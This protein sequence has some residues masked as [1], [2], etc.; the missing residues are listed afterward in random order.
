[1]I[2][3]KKILKAVIHDWRGYLVA[4]VL[5]ALATW[6]KYLAQPNI[7]PTDVP[8]LYLLAIVPTAIFFGL[9]P[10]I[11]VCIL[12]LLAYDYFFISPVHSFDV[13]RIINAPILVIFLFVG[14][15]FS[16]LSSNLRR[17]N[18]IAAKEIS[19]R[20]QT[21]TE[22]VKYKDHLEDL[23]AQ[24]TAELEKTNLNL[25]EEVAE[26]KQAEEALNKIREELELRVKERTKE[27]SGAVES[28]KS[29]ITERKL[30]EALVAAQNKQFN[31]V[32]DMLPAY[33][34]L[35]SPDYHVPFA[36]RFFRE[37][38]GE[39][40]GKRCF[41]YLFNRTEPCEVCETYKVLKTNAPLQWDWIGPDGHN[42]SIF[43]FP[44]ADK[45][46][47]NL[48]MEVGIDVTEEKRAHEALRKAHDELEFRV[49]ERTREL[50]ET[51]DYLDNLFNYANA[52]IIVWNP[53]FKITRFNH[54]F[55]R[56]TAFNAKEVLGKELDIL[57]PLNS[58]EASM[59]LIRKLVTGEHWE[60]V[61][62]PILRTD[63]TVRTVLWNSATIYTPDEI[64][65]VA[66][67]AQGQDITERKQAENAL[68]ETL[69]RYRTVAENT[70]DFE[71]SIDPAGR[72]LYASPACQRI[73]GRS[74]SEFLADPGLRRRTIH[75]DDLEIFDQHL[76]NEQKK[77]VREIEY[78]ILHT[79]GFYR[80]IAHACQPVFDEHGQYLGI[81]GTNRD[82]TERKKAE[83]AL[84][85]TT[86]YLDNLFNYANAPIIVWNPEYKIT[87]FNHAFERL[88]GLSAD[89]VLGE[90]LDILFPPDSREASMNLIHQ[91]V[92]GERWEVV[93]IP[94]LRTDGG[95]R[96]VLWNSANLFA[97]DGKTV[98]STIAQGQDITE[99]KKAEKALKETS[100]YLDNL[101]NYANAPIIVWNPEYKITR[102]NHAFERLTGLSAD[103]VLGKKLDIL[104]PQESRENSFAS[105]P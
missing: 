43:D 21:E 5:V 17:K 23:V 76:I 62:I 13:T 61:E 16:Y 64:T 87:R 75:P 73:Y 52:P 29:E 59:N 35:L 18:Q 94:I 42:Y 25:Q 26:R 41:E 85:E 56:L 50:R 1:M 93:E 99:R 11:L 55:E 98:V 22:L 37:R 30:A 65:P 24:R 36:N 48:I 10:S 28:L 66:T 79:D 44:F 90:K 74:S 101:I 80:W 86:D 51:T 60:V 68:E 91:L 100:D 69:L 58:R 83:E 38:F 84:K 67:I 40:H 14:V 54:A 63:G 9:G 12:S 4:I 2:R 97:P 82:I 27:L 15:L 78:R 49:K 81:R 8:I 39:S 45:D 57:F 20:K 103:A 46:G 92:T 3:L 72:Y 34:V 89:G 71:F 7:I 47:S 33:L 102:F 32:L 77:S 96:T 88:T 31:E 104:F 95:V 53:E 105:H 19:V 6:L 70:Y